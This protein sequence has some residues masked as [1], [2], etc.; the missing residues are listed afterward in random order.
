MT[1][2]A[3][4]GERIDVV[5]VAGGLW[6]D[7]DFARLE[8]LKLL[9]EHEEFRVRCQPDFEDTTWLEPGG[10]FQARILV[11][12]TCDVRPSPRAQQVIRRLGGTRRAHGRPARHELVAGSDR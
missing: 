7:F 8:L 4:Q 10:P 11:T 2:G 5:L 9:A 3:H 1:D 12:Y 6:H